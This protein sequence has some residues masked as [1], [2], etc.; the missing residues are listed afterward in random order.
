MSKFKIYNKSSLWL[1]NNSNFIF[2][3]SFEE[4]IKKLFNV[5]YKA[6]LK[7]FSFEVFFVFKTFSKGVM[8]YT[9]CGSRKNFNLFFSS[10]SFNSSNCIGTNSSKRNFCS[11]LFNFF[12]LLLNCRFSNK[13]YIYYFLVKIK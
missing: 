13:L 3:S 5:S 8:F 2:S 7:Y 11:S 6:L 9:L 12:I 4:F 10:V 1:S